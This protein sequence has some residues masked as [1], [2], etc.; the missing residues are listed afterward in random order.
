MERQMM[1][2]NLGED[3]KGIGLNL[4]MLLND[5]VMIQYEPVLVGI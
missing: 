3:K 1:G 5:S 2:M 4:A